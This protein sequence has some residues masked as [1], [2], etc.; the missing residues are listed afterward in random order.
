MYRQNHNYQKN[1]IVL[2]NTVDN[3]FVSESDF[4]SER[5]VG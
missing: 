1:S 5:N 4:W 3:C 2:F